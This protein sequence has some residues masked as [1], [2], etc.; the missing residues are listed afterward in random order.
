MQT[1]IVVSVTSTPVAVFHFIISNHVLWMEG[2]VLRIATAKNIC[3][4]VVGKSPASWAITCFLGGRG[5]SGGNCAGAGNCP[6]GIVLEW[7]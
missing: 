5:L 3:F 1:L 6:G 2:T 7:Q 4:H